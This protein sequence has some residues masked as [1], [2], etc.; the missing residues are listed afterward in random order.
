MEQALF[1][2]QL[3]QN[4]DFAPNT[5][6]FNMFTSAVVRSMVSG[7]LPTKAPTPDGAKCRFCGSSE[8]N[9]TIIP[10]GGPYSGRITCSTCGKEES[11]ISHMAY[12]MVSVEPVVTRYKRPEQFNHLTNDAT[13]QQ[14]VGG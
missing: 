2:K 3:K 9:R 14:E 10:V 8:I 7:L 11:V 5:E 1:D 4:K 6:P 13:D 12:N